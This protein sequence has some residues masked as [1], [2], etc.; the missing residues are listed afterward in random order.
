MAGSTIMLLMTYMQ[1]LRKTNLECFSVDRGFAWSGYTMSTSAWTRLYVSG[2]RIKNQNRLARADAV[3]S[4]PAITARAPS[5]A[6]SRRVGFCFS[7]PASS[8][9]FYRQGLSVPRSIKSL[10]DGTKGPS[11][12]SPPWLFAS[13][14]QN[15]I[16]WVSTVHWRQP[17]ASP[18]G[19][20]PKACVK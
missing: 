20:H 12:L 14:S 4:A 8:D 3:V 13:H 15:Q 7:S 10:Q 11:K 5:E 2:L 17:G 18:I 1:A 19:G 9:W 16:S 6:T